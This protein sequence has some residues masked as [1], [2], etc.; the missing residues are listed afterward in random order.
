MIRI[1][2]IFGRQWNL[3]RAQVACKFLRSCRT[4]P[5]R[6]W[7]SAC[8]VYGE[9]EQKK[10]AV[11]VAVDSSEP[12]TATYYSCSILSN[13]TASVRFTTFDRTMTVLLLVSTSR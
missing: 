7:L 6:Q 3:P 10:D 2:P 12:H 5:R 11:P 4:R 1:F 13:P 8:H 9:N